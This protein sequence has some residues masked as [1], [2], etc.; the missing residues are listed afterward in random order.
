MPK[1]IMFVGERVYNRI[2]IKLQQF[3]SFVH[4]KLLT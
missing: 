1:Q 4:F 3:L 2:F